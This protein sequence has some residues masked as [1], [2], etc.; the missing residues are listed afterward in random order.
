MRMDSNEKQQHQQHQ[1]L[2]SLPVDCIA[3]NQ[4]P[5]K[6]RKRSVFEGSDQ[7][8]QKTE[9]DSATINW[10]MADLSNWLKASKHPSSDSCATVITS[11]LASTPDKWLANPKFVKTP[12]AAAVASLEAVPQPPD[13]KISHR[14]HHSNTSNF[15]NLSLRLNGPGVKEEEHL[16]QSA[17]QFRT[18]SE[19]VE[20]TLNR[21]ATLFED[22]TVSQ[23]IKKLADTNALKHYPFSAA[24]DNVFDWNVPPKH[25]ADTATAAVVPMDTLSTVVVVVDDPAVD[26]QQQQLQQLKVK[27][28]L[29]LPTDPSYWLKQYPPPKQNRPMNEMAEDL[30]CWESVLGWKSILEKIHGSGEDGW[31]APSSRAIKNEAGTD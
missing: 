21:L 25:Y 29:A 28:P 6:P 22:K 4:Q 2:S 17:Q 10:A 26:Q 24:V 23:P 20:E 13:A 15:A 18:I 31:L 1:L 30:C 14:Q 27:T 5:L 16:L 7:L 11:V 8:K 19:S 3:K 12:F 9:T